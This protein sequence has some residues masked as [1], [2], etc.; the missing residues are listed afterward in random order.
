MSLQ[1]GD[2]MVMNFV[3]TGRFMLWLE[4]GVVG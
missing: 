4:T 2:N 1:H 3:L